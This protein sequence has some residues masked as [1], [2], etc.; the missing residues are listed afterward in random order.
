MNINTQEQ[1]DARYYFVQLLITADEIY[2][3][4]KESGA[5]NLE[6]WFNETQRCTCGQC[7]QVPRDIVHAMVQHIHNDVFIDAI[8]E[9]NWID[10]IILIYDDLIEN[11]PEDDHNLR[12]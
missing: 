9:R 6:L 5:K 1:V 11:E 8:Q 4:F 10:Q 2:E 7:H 3:E 12:N